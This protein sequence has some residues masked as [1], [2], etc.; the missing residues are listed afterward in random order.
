MDAFA[1]MTVSYIVAAVASAI[2]FF[3]VGKGGNL[4]NEIMTNANW[5]SFVLGLT[6]VGL[7]VGAIFMYKVGWN[8]NTG[9]VVQAILVA[10]ALLFVGYLLYKEAITVN[11]VLGI[12][13]CL[14]GLYFINKN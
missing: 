4:P 8:V 10:I 11:K 13:I 9:N 12:V 3:T 2:L 6:M 5:A 7:E 1:A 14:V